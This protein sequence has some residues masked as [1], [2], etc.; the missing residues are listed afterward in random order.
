MAGLAGA[1]AFAQTTFEAVGVRAQGMGGAFVAV[2][3]DATAVYWNPGAMATVGLFN[4]AVERSDGTVGRT[5]VNSDGTVRVS[6][7][8][9]GLRDQT[10]TLVAMGVPPVGLAYYRLQTVEV[11]SPRGD[12]PAVVGASLTTDNIALNLLHSL[13][14]GVHV[15]ATLRLVHG[16]AANGF[17]T[18]PGLSGQDAEGLLSAAGDLEGRSSWAFDVDA[19]V[20]V[21]RGRWRAGLTAR[22]LAAPEFDLPENVPGVDLYAVTV[23]RQVRAGA[24]FLPTSSTTVAVDMDLTRTETAFGNV[25]RLAMGLEQTLAPRVVVRG[26]F[27]VNTADGARP[28]AA[29]GASVAVRSSLWIDAHANLGAH[30]AERRWGVGVRMGI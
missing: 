3:D 14:D 7:S 25:R 21:A 2:A 15:G 30:D 10:G 18:G 23:S 19:G 13:A 5:G 6:S 11:A 20:L 4:A 27:N 16:S 22:N 24:A 9:L 28:A 12:A 1:P 26:G 17:L 8:P 29:F